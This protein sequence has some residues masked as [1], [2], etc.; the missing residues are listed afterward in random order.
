MQR[1]LRNRYVLTF[2]LMAAVAVGWNVYV[3]LHDDGL[4]VGRVVGVDGAAA[5]GVTVTFYERTLTTLEP[6]G[7]VVTGPD[8]GFRFNGQAA[9]H[10]VLVAAKAGAGASPRTAYRRYFRGQNVVL[11]APLRL[12]PGR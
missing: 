6:R 1:L 7:T 8:G 10:F 4:V 3:A 9:H 12:E 11:S 5:A 2:G